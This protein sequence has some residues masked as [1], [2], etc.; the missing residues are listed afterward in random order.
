MPEMRTDLSGLNGPR[1]PQAKA[2]DI[3]KGGGVFRGAEVQVVDVNSLISDAAEELTSV[4]SEETEKDVSDR[5][6]EEGKRSDS[7]ERFMRTGEVNELLKSLADLDK[8]SLH[9]GI[10]ALLQRQSVDPRELREEARDQF[11][12][13]AHQY[14]ALRGLLDVLKGRGAAKEQ[15][16]AA[17]A[18]LD[19]LVEEHGSAIRAAIN[20]GPAS[21]EFVLTGL[22]D[23]QSL[24][25]AYR[26]NIRDYKNMSAVLDDLTQRFGE[27]DLEKSIRFMTK[28]LSADL[29]ADGSSIDEAKLNVILKDMHRLKT[30]TTVLGNCDI[31]AARA[32]ANGASQAFTSAKVLREIVP[33]QDA[34]RVVPDHIAAIPERA[35]LN[36]VSKQINFLSDF[37]EMARLIPLESFVRA[38]NREKLMEAI[39]DALDEKIAREEEEE[40]A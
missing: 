4:L 21:K 27:G 22:G 8:K 31:L 32:Q 16:D 7:L 33:L 11:R 14:A 5:E 37:K 13:P 3:G 18:A 36:D 28:A 17:E 2:P 35:G 20:I 29:E 25:D 24:R 1:A 39:Q 10:K 26:S 19:S 40:V 23:A 34:I 6:V 9:R 15:V 12:E 38:E 30:L